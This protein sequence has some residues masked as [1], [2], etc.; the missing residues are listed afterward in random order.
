ML[1]ISKLKKHTVIKNM[2]CLAVANIAKQIFS[3]IGA[4]VIPKFLG[5]TD[6]GAYQT[7]MVYVSI[8]ALFTFEGVHKVIIRQCSQHPED[9]QKIYANIIGVK[10]LCNIGS[11]FL[12][13]ISLFF[14]QYDVVVKSYIAFFSISLFLN[15]VSS[16]YSSIFQVRQISS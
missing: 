1:N 16:F 5:P 12:V 14:V 4:F 11:V 8:F 6:Y 9:A 2:S 13:L 3:L 15:G 7:V 10:H